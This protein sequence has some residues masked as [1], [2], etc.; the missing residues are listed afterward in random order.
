M[1]FSLFLVLLAVLLTGISQVLLKIGSA[2]QGKRKKSILD[3]Y[4]NLPTLFAYGLLLCVTVISIIALTG[5][6]PLKM[7]YAIMSLNLV[8]VV[9]LSWGILKEEINKKM[10]WGIILI[11]IG[12]V[13]F[14]IDTVNSIMP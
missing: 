8:V 5:R 13:I 10:V 14:N 7:F 9:G 3:A 2:H 6:I 1:I 11:V 12:I 4:L